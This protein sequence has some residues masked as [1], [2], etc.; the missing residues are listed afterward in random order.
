MKYQNN[1]FV[2]IFVII[3]YMQLVIFRNEN[4]Q[5]IMRL[6]YKLALPLNFIVQRAII[7]GSHYALL[8]TLWLYNSAFDYNSCLSVRKIFSELY[9]RAC[10]YIRFPLCVVVFTA[11]DY[12]S[13]LSLRKFL[14]FSSSSFA[15]ITCRYL[16]WNGFYKINAY[17]R[18]FSWK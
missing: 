1:F 14:F 9:C 3:H 4:F 15:Q 10:Y 13:C 6:I 16:L 5:L 7:Y 11:F 17:M 12:N 2:A 8:Y 18:L